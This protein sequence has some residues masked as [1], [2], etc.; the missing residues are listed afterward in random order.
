MSKIT[1]TQIT[2]LPD[3]KRKKNDVLNEEN[4]TQTQITKLPNKKKR[5]HDVLS[6]ENEN[7]I[8]YLSGTNSFNIQK[9]VF[10]VAVE[11]A[12]SSNKHRLEFLHD[13]Q[14]VE[15]EIRDEYN[16][17]RKLFPLKKRSKYFHDGKK[18]ADKIIGAIKGN[19]ILIKR[20]EEKIIEIQEFDDEESEE[21]SEKE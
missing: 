15:E 21:E 5:K 20:I 6:E 18:F 8:K 4:E 17:M 14:K 16:R 10:D 11:K 2:E 1:Q 7:E 9:D 3:K 12:F 19:E 13:Y